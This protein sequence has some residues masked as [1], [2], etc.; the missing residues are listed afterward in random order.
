MCK[1][2]TDER[3]SSFFEI[4]SG[5]LN[6]RFT[7]IEFDDDERETYRDFSQSFFEVVSKLETGTKYFDDAVNVLSK[8]KEL[9]R[10]VMLED[11]IPT[12]SSVVE[13]FVNGSFSFK[14]QASFPVRTL[15]AFI[16]LF[17]SCSKE[18]QNIIL[19]N[20]HTRLDSLER[21]HPKIDFDD[22]IPF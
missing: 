22:D 9:H 20:I 16:E 12:P 10:S 21:Y 1:Q 15:K 17:R 5:I 2:S 4:K 14:R 7:E 13:C 19:S 11:Y 6:E 18:K 3:I 8:T